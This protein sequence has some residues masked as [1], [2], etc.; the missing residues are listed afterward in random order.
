MNKI[1]YFEILCGVTICSSVAISIVDVLFE[2]E[3]NMKYENSA[4]RRS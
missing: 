2:F 3:F 1:T 4:E